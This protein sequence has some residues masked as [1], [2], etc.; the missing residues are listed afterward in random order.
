MEYFRKYLITLRKYENLNQFSLKVSTMM[1]IASLV[2]ILL[3]FLMDLFLPHEYFTNMLRGVIAVATGFTL[4]SFSYLFSVK[5][6]HKKMS[7]DRFYK[8]ARERFSHRQR[9]NFSIAVGTL[10]LAFIMLS[11]NSGL[12]FTL[13]SILAVFVGFILV[14]FC[15][16]NRSEF[17]KGVHEIPDIRD[18]E[19]QKERREQAQIRQHKTKKKEKKRIKW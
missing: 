6:T 18:L 7:M 5:R 14:A 9:V 12:V 15:R 11:S 10:T 2:G 17:I 1:L 8:T 16:R 13:K 19:K 4:F 3:G